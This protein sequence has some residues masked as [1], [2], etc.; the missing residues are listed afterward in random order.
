MVILTPCQS[1][2]QK[3]P[4]PNKILRNVCY[5]S[6]FYCPVRLMYMS[7]D[8]IPELCAKCTLPARYGFTLRKITSTHMDYSIYRTGSLLP[9]IISKMDDI[10]LIK[11]LNAKFFDHSISEGF[12]HA[13]VT[14]PA[15][16]AEFDYERLELLG[17]YFFPK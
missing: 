16:T 3:I 4:L 9:S 15:A 14:S 8:L 17:S 5:E 13:A 6:S 10:L 2:I 12:L 1:L 7:I 11:E